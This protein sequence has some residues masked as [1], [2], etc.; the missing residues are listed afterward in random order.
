MYRVRLAFGLFLI[1]TLFST[2]AFSQTQTAV[3]STSVLEIRQVINAHIVQQGVPPSNVTG[4]LISAADAFIFLDKYRPDYDVFSPMRWV[5][6]SSLIS[7]DGLAILIQEPVY[8]DIAVYFPEPINM[9]HPNIQ[10][11]LIV[12]LIGSGFNAKG[13]SGKYDAPAGHLE[14]KCVS[15]DQMSCGVCPSDSGHP[16]FD[17]SL[18]PDDNTAFHKHPLDTVWNIR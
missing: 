13:F 4:T 14:C 2:S 6:L 1:L 5:W 9:D 7:A 18:D 12:E 15:G 3:Y 17:L 11:G 8:G 10:R 16:L